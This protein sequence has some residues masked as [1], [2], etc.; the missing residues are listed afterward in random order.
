MIHRTT[1]LVS[2]SWLAL[3]TALSACSTS[4]DK[5]AVASAGNSAVCS[6]KN[7]EMCIIPGNLELDVAIDS[8]L[9]ELKDQP[10]GPNGPAKVAC[11]ELNYPGAEPKV[12]AEKDQRG[13][14]ICLFNHTSSMN[15]ALN[16]LSTYI[17]DFETVD[18]ASDYSDAAWA[19]AQ[20]TNGSL[21]HNLESPDLRRYLAETK[22]HITK[23]AQSSVAGIQLEN[24]FMNRFIVPM[25]E[26][27]PKSILLGVPLPESTGDAAAA[28]LKAV[29]GHEVFHSIYFH[30][31]LMKK[32]VK[33]YIDAT[34]A[35][36]V[37]L[38]KKRLGQKGY[39]V[40]N[41]DGS[42]P[43]P[44][45]NYMFYNETAAYLL[46]SGACTDGAF[47][48]YIDESVEDLVPVSKTAPLVVRHAAKL[49]EIL[50]GQQV[51][52]ANWAQ[53]WSPDL[54]KAGCHL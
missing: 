36:D 24:E 11:A 13:T 50:V 6:G 51:I 22:A 44:K 32:L 26:K 39:A 8:V 18:A 45:Q 54:L 20:L 10:R 38:M 46:E 40:E 21:G 14:F 9:A 48:S 2:V 7:I 1:R 29:L 19:A 5:S 23:R 27:K 28:E 42:A 3:A 52:E 49:R 47:M 33:T 25:I 4:Q 37:A 31:D 16:R 53:K 15:M 17:E 41:E 35:E 12:L 34:S 30:S 43:T